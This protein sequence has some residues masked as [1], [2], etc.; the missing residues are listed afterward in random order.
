V[1]DAFRNSGSLYTAGHQ[2]GALQSMIT[3]RLS[4]Q[5]ED[6]D[7]DVEHG[8]PPWSASGCMSVSR[9]ALVAAVLQT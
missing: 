4:F 8:E 1:Y 9:F 3:D 5:A 6:E 2:E 7:E